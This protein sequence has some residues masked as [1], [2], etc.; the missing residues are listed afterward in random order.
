MEQWEINYRSVSFIEKR[1]EESRVRVFRLIREEG[2]AASS[3]SNSTSEP[4]WMHFDVVMCSVTPAFPVSESKVHFDVS[5]LLVSILAFYN[6]LNNEADM[7]KYRRILEVQI[8]TLWRQDCVR[9]VKWVL[10][11]LVKVPCRNGDLQT[12]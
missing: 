5:H 4:S 9:Q 2:S 11:K 3:A 8:H 6:C 10:E 7:A 1:A 12:A